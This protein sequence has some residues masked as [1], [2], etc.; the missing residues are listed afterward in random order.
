[1][2]REAAAGLVFLFGD[3]TLPEMGG[4]RVLNDPTKESFLVLGWDPVPGAAGY[5]F[6]S[7]GSKVTHTW[8]PLFRRD[9][10][11]AACNTRF[12]KD[13]AWYKVEVLFVAVELNYP[14]NRSHTEISHVGL[15]LEVGGG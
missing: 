4:L 14:S 8:D 6:S 3:E 11:Y 12:P 5:R 7:E 9:S 2:S 10:R 1:M 15:T 13:K